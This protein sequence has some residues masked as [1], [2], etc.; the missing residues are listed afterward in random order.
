LNLTILPG[1]KLGVL[2]KSGT[3]KSTLLKLIAGVLE[4][5][6]G[7]VKVNGI[8]MKDDYLAEA[9]S[10]LNQKPHLFNTS[11][12]NNIKIARLEAT[13]KEVKDVIE[14]AQLNELINQL[15]NCLNTN[16]EVMGKK[17]SVGEGKRIALERVLFQDTLIIIMYDR[18]I[19]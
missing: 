13:K 3:G 12:L 4:P 6:H 5:D 10:V 15:P 17:F 1:E 19:I 9:V 2:G 14:Q 16:I 18:K 7:E 8:D 11:I